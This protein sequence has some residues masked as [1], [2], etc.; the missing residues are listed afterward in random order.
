MRAAEA[1]GYADL[2]SAPGALTLLAP[3]NAAFDNLSPGLLDKLLDD[4][5]K[6]QLQ[7]LLQYHL[8]PGVVTSADLA[9]GLSLATLNGE[10]VTFD[11]DLPLG[12]RV[13][14]NALVLTDIVDVPASNGVIHGVSEVL[15]PASVTSN[16]VDIA[17]ANDDFKTLVM[18]VT[19]AGLAETLSGEGPFTVFGK[20]T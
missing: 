9:D 15:V 20:Y 18:A 6:P 12:P 8:L 16:I 4:I 17:A 19:A 10:N 7:D 3:P 5:W 14:E 1:A 13:N 2:L 11:T